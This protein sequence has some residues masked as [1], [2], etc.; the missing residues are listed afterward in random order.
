MEEYKEIKNATQYLCSNYGNVKSKRYNKPLKGSPN[1]SG[2]LRVQLG[3]PKVKMFIHKL[4]AL[5][6]LPKIPGKY[7]VNHKD[8]NKQNNHVDNL[9]WCSASENMVHYHKNKTENKS[10]KGEKHH[11][12]KLTEIQVIEIK[13]L[14]NQGFNCVYIGEKFNVHRK[15]ISDI[16]NKKTWK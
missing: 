4:I 7:Y 14:L 6:F 12:S 3:S 15:T 2:Y 1:S 13:K 8:G 5:T 9:E 10:I 16:K 11:Q